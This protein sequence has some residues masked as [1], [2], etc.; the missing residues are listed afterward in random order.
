MIEHK[1]LRAN[2]HKLLA[3]SPSELVDL[4]T[5]PHEAIANPIPVDARIV[6]TMYDPY[7]DRVLVRLFSPSFDM[8]EE[9]DA[10]PF[11]TVPTY[12]LVNA[13]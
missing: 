2:R 1:E 12:R 8:L 13:K 4:M 6:G 11:V 7:T 9:G 3:I 10:I 5:Y